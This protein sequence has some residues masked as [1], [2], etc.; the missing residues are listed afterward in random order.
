MRPSYWF[1]AL[2]WV[3]LCFQFGFAEKA[4]DQTEHFVHLQTIYRDLISTG[5]KNYAFYQRLKEIAQQGYPEARYAYAVLQLVG[6]TTYVDRDT[7][8]AIAEFELLS[9]ENGLPAAQQV[10]GFIYGIGLGVN[11][12]QAKALVYLT[13]AAL[14]GDIRAHMML[15]F[16]YLHGSGVAKSCETS[17]AH[18]RKVA[19]FVEQETDPVGTIETERLRLSEEVKNRKSAT[20]QDIIQ[21]YK[22]NADWGDVKSQLVMGQVYY[23]GSHG[24][25]QSFEEAFRYLSAASDEGDTKAKAFLGDMYFLGRGVEKNYETARKFYEASV[26]KPNAYGQ[27]G[28]G[29]LY[30]GG[31]GVPANDAKAFEYFK[32]AAALGLAD[33]QYHLGLLY[34]SGIAT[35]RDYRSALDHFRVAAQ[36]G[37]VLAMY[38]MGLMHAT[39]TGT[40]RS[41]EIAAKFFK[42]VAERGESSKMFSL[43]F[44]QYEAGNIE[45]AAVMY[46]ELA[47]LGFEIGQNNAAFMLDSESLPGFDV[48]GSYARAFM[49][50]KRSANQGHVQS[51]LTVGD[52]YY[53]GRGTEVDYTAAVNQYRAAADASHP[54]AMFNLGYMHEYGISLPVDYHLAKR[55]Y[56][57]AAE[58]SPDAK[59]PRIFAMAVLQTKMYMQQLSTEPFFA[60]AVNN[61]QSGSF[62]YPTLGQLEK[63]IEN[64][65]TA[66][67]LVL[68]ACLSIVVLARQL[69]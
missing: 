38:N 2:I 24:T 1:C 5:I 20:E 17:L 36:Q 61:I 25:V 52:Y 41:C 19:D 42:N 35:K 40:P 49:N 30:L 62:P 45:A 8:G 53:Y 14:G 26:L 33:A 32:A 4:S 46:M 10:L 37:H 57:L 51:L 3:T 27:H 47:E 6:N 58:T 69:Q 68:I 50:W 7:A 66:L 55:Y 16:R 34:Y 28:L 21:Y 29:K 15:G 43:A 31:H 11:S 56:D 44:Q 59:I 39:G 63:F 67:V 18:Y 13:F 22:F 9:K 48:N 65:E 64:S 23:Q 54:Q 60:S 12:S